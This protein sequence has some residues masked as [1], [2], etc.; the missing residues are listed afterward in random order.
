MGD[1]LSQEELDALLSGG[2]DLDSSDIEI[3]QSLDTSAET[4][5]DFDDALT[6]EQKDVL[7][8]IGNIS[9]GTAATTLFA[10]LNGHKVLITTPVVTI[11][12]WDILSKSYSRPCVGIKVNYIE[13]LTGSNILILREEDVKVIADLMMGGEGV[14]EQP[15]VL[16]E[17]EFSAIGEAMNQ[18]VGSSSTSISSVIGRKID[19]DTPV[20]MALAFGEDDFFEKTGFDAAEVVACVSF[21]MEVG[22]LI[23][24]EITQIMPLDFAKDLV[25]T[26]MQD[27]AT[28]EPAAAE[29]PAPAAAAPAAP[30]PAAAP[31]PAPAAAAP[32]PATPPPVYSPSAPPPPQDAY[33]QGAPPQQPGYPPQQPYPPQPGYP[34]P[35]EGYP[36]A[37]YPPPPPGYY[38][39]PPYHQPTMYPQP[40]AAQTAQPAQFE[41]LDITE[42][43]QQKE[44][45]GIIM[46]VPLEVT[47]ELGRTSRKIREILE[48]VPGTIV[49]LD[50]LAGEPIDILVNGKF[51]ATGE[52]VVVDENFAVR[53][54][55][56]VNVEKRI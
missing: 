31:A 6:N 21:R 55:D 41:A 26:M 3:D 17:M 20:A 25:S 45:M 48:F 39:P 37:G 24:S 18:M 56:I 10:L 30:Q 51:V 44:N 2:D 42:L 11:K 12:T 5:S 50:K 52:V 54:T 32:T 22:D 35:Q 43:S 13:G 15:V 4:P 46:D 1:M 29:S 38:P 28:T 34:P 49:D 23:D 40:Y 14:V 53:V 9:M 16:S 19:I 36:P 47:V 27:L 33:A 7:G 8:E